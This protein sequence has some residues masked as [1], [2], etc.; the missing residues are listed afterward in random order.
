MIYGSMETKFSLLFTRMN[1]L[2][3][4]LKNLIIE[5]RGLK[6]SRT[7]HL[8]IQNICKFTAML[9]LNPIIAH[10]DAEY[11]TFPEKAFKPERSEQGITFFC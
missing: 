3:C 7:P 1:L 8:T 11:A 6:I 4:I 5:D 10:L 2:L 9:K